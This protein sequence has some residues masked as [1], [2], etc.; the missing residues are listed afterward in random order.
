M[1]Q[2]PWPEDIYAVARLDWC[3]SLD[4]PEGGPV[5]QLLCNNLARQCGS[6]TNATNDRARIA[7]TAPQL[8]ELLEPA[9]IEAWSGRCPRARAQGV[10]NLGGAKSY[11]QELWDAFAQPRQDRAYER[12]NE[13]L[14]RKRSE[15]EEAALESADEQPGLLSEAV[16]PAMLDRERNTA[17][18][19]MLLDAKP[20][21]VVSD[22]AIR[23]LPFL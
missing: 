16:I 2:Y 21:R 19:A 22:Y 12:I 1:S 5:A 14:R 17:L 7:R 10:C 6:F 23:G 20:K 3:R 15:G 9:E 4:T 8:Q 13:D 11:R 18:D